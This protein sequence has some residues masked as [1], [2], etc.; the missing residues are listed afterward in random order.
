MRLSMAFPT[1]CWIL[2]TVLFHFV[3]L[4]VYEQKKIYYFMVYHYAY[5]YEI[6]LTFTLKFSE[7][8]F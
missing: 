6:T 4:D 8:S 5:L 3:F 1:R 7:K 2:I